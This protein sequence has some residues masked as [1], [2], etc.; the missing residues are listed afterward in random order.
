MTAKTESKTIYERI[1]PYVEYLDYI[2]ANN[3]DLYVNKR[4][5]DVM[6]EKSL[7]NSKIT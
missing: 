7:N 1:G 6:F 3:I 4:A 5:I 2:D